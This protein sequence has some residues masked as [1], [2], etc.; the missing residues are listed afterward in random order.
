MPEL[1]LAS[2]SPRRRELLSRAGFR[3]T[4]AESPYIEDMTLP[5]D[6]SE[7][8]AVMAEGK[9]RAINAPDAVVLGADTIVVLGRSVLGK[10]LDAEDAA[11]M[12]ARLSGA[13]HEVI[14]GYA[15]ID[16]SSGETSSGAVT[17]RVRFRAI[18]DAEISEYIAT[19]EPMGKA[20][21]YAIQGGAS[22]FVESIDGPLDNVM[23]L[24]MKEV[25]EA[26]ARSGILPG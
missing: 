23:G 2:A 26:L 5:L 9:A 19:R 13:V 6:P 20:G 8:A 16:N 15:V 14:T 12:L 25:G 22:K 1:M 18:T 7:L 17:T 24:P 10:P 4:V 3:F 11:R 21:A